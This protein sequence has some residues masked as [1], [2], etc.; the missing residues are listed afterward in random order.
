MS[1]TSYGSGLWATENLHDTTPE[2]NQVESYPF[3]HPMRVFYDPYNSG[4]VWIAS[5]GNGLK[6]GNVS[7]LTNNK[8]KLKVK[9]YLEGAYN[10]ATGEMNLTL[11]PEIPTTSPYSQDQRYVNTVPSQAV[12]WI[13]VQLRKTPD[14]N[15]ITSKSVFINK[16]GILINDDGTSEVIELS[17]ANDNYFIVLKH[18]NHLTVMSANAVPLNSTTSTSYD[19][20]TGENQF[21]GTGGAKQLE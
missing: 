5:F 1:V 14:G 13:L 19:F 15:A 7:E 4:K 16:N 20:T 8:V 17:G 10:S 21:Y 9:I 11:N 18:R 3:K 2:F 12:D 6:V